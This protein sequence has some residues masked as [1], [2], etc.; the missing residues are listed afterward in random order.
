MGRGVVAWFQL[1]LSYSVVVEVADLPMHS[2]DQIYD[3]AKD[4]FLR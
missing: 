2:I 1:V 4:D 3:R